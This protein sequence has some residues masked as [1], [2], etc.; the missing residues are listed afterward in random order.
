[1]LD[2]LRRTNMKQG[3]DS[4]SLMSTCSKLV[5]EGGKDFK[6]GRE[7]FSY[8]T[9]YR[10]TTR[11]PLYATLTRSNIVFAVNKLNQFIDDPKEAH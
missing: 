11:A 10:S 7:S 4:L 1:M 5:K 3:N 9:V 8:K 6:E 2:L